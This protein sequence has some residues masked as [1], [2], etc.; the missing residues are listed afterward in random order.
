MFRHR[1]LVSIIIAAHAAGKKVTFS[2]PMR[3]THSFS[4]VHFTSSDD[5]PEQVECVIDETRYKLKDNHKITLKAVDEEQFSYDHYYV[6][7]LESLMK[8]SP[9]VYVMLID[10]VKYEHVENVAA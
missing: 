3:P 6:S 5:E 9:D 7:D 8:R 2:V 1:E 4:F 10:G